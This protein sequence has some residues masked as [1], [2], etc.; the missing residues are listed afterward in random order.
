MVE[1]MK[2][3]GMLGTDK[4][5][6][7]MSCT[8]YWLV[9]WKQV[10]CVHKLLRVAAM[11]SKECRSVRRAVYS[12]DADVYSLRVRTSYIVVYDR[13]LKCQTMRDVTCFGQGI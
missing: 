12:I 7:S 3:P 1:R 10:V 8:N 6:L 13:R 9:G 4:D 5:I 11:W 2:E